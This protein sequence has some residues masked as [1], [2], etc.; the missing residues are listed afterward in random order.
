MADQAGREEILEE[1]EQFRKDN[2]DDDE[3]YGVIADYVEQ[4]QEETGYYKPKKEVPPQE[5]EPGMA[6]AIQIYKIISEANSWIVSDMAQLTYAIAK[7][8]DFHYKFYTK[9]GTKE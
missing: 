6:I 5:P 2:P 9:H 1:I 4:M 3:F 8:L 7:D